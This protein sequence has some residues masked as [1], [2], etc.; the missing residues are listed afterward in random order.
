MFVG[1]I[2]T[3]GSLT[4]YGCEVTVTTAAAG[5]VL[6]TGTYTTVGA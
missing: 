3:P 2:I 5:P 6:W 4:P 1:T